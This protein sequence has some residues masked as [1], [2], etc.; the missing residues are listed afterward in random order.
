MIN[1]IRIGWGKENPAFRQLFS[2]QLMPEGSRSQI[3]SLNEL[4]RVCT[5]ADTA[6]RM[7]RAFYEIDVTALAPH[8]RCPTL[9]L[10]G[11]CDAAIPFEEGR[12]LA[13]LIPNSRF[14]PLETNNHVLLEDEPAW[15]RFL[16]EMRR[17]LPAGRPASGPFA[18]LTPREQEVLDWIAR[19]RSNDQI[20]DRLC[21]SPKTVRNHITHIF[22]KL[23]VARRAEAIVE[24]REAGFGHGEP[25]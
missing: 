18:D 4:A 7:E 16:E 8:V 9:V 6:A 10:H 5:T 22:R 1:V 2:T 25:S 17:F 20:A 19:G 3:R 11:R 21:I 14:V 24:A 13:G 15:R 12:R 23:D